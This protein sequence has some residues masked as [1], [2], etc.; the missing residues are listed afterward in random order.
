MPTRQYVGARYVPK[1]ADPIAWD[2]N[3]TYESLTIVT[4]LNDSYTSK[5]NVPVGIP[6]SNTEYWVNTGNYNAQVE[7]YRQEVVE[8]KEDVENLEN[9]FNF[10]YVTKIGDTISSI[11]SKISGIPSVTLVVDANVNIV[12]NDVLSN[13]ISIIYGNGGKFIANS[14]SNL[15]LDHNT[16][17]ISN[18]PLFENVVIKTSGILN[19][20]EVTP[21]LWG[22]Y[23]GAENNGDKINYMMASMFK[24]TRFTKGLWVCYPTN[25]QSGKTFVFDD[26]A[27]IDGIVHIATGEGTT[28]YNTTVEGKIVST[29][30]V[31]TYNCNGVNIPDGI[32]ILGS[33]TAYP[34]QSLEGCSKG[35]HIYYN[36]KN[37]NIGDI[38]VDE[39]KQ[40]SDGVM[41]SALEIDGNGE[42]A[43]AENVYIKSIISGNNTSSYSSLFIAN[44][45]NIFIGK[46]KNGSNILPSTDVL[47][48]KSTDVR[49]GSCFVTSTNAA[50]NNEIFNIS[51]SEFISIDSVNIYSASSNTAFGLCFNNSKTCNIGI[52]K[53]QNCSQGIRL[54]NSAYITFMMH[55]SLN[56]TTKVA[57]SNS[58]YY[59]AYTA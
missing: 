36:S 21:L 3:R 8:Y 48:L 2:M 59:I 38:I 20:S 12:N 30:R 17:I 18:R 6:I 25:V 29:V 47:I 26:G 10:I 14:S 40:R 50:S 7:Q 27:I 22:A 32:H 46:Y 19:K 39:V 31:G 1:F 15:F 5:K 16:D 52:T 33:N 54:V 9:K 28:V 42:Q 24:R 45:S 44:S 13:N 41:N 35:I 55:H 23:E 34:N 4:Y 49:L 11:N 43:G 53:T 58:T 57:E 37:M 51:E 56:D